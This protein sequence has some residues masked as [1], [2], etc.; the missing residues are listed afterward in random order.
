[1]ASKAKW[2]A[3]DS[4]Y[5]AGSL[6]FQSQKHSSEAWASI[7]IRE[8]RISSNA[9]T[10]FVDLSS[11]GPS[12]LRPSFENFIQILQSSGLNGPILL[13]GEP[14]KI[15]EGAQFYV[16]RHEAGFLDR[17]TFDSSVVAVKEPKFPTTHNE[18]I[19][20]AEPRVQRSLTHIL[21]EIKA[22]THEKLRFHPNIVRLLSWAYQEDFNR[23]LV[24]VLELARE[25]LE[26]ALANR[27]PPSIYQRARFCNDMANGLDA[28][29]G[30]GFIHGDLKPANVLIFFEP[31]RPIAKLA[32]FGYAKEQGVAN[33]TGTLGWQAPEKTSSMEADRYAYGLLVWSIFLLGGDVPPSRNVLNS[34]ANIAIR[35][36]DDSMLKNQ[37][38]IYTKIYTAL[39]H[40]LQE[41]EKQRPSLLVPFFDYT[42]EL[43]Q[44]P[45][46]VGRSRA[47]HF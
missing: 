22:L 24:L 36:L 39:H 2:N 23:S 17:S 11:L 14:E 45:R 3:F 21:N 25:D 43:Q 6:E 26:K 38:Q 41:D 5:E 28:I 29:H 12:A 34:Q 44:T 33:E 4:S 27:D 15:G 7:S 1:M 8:S 9:S 46:S 31:I 42:H 16:Y 47:K 19:D 35:N 10:D 13:I 30:A 37:D 20:L 40:C 32:D 18:P